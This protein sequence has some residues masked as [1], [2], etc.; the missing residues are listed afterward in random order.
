MSRIER[1]MPDCR[2]TYLSNFSTSFFPESLNLDNSRR[3]ETISAIL[4]ALSSNKTALEGIGVRD[5]AGW[6]SPEFA[7]RIAA[8]PL[9]TKRKSRARGPASRLVFARKSE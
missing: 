6:L 4:Q 1:H 8:A 7:Q 5:L 3:T 2:S 9:S